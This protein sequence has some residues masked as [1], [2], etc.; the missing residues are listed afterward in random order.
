MTTTQ[1][2]PLIGRTV[3]G[4]YLVESH[5]ADGGMGS[6]YVALDTRLDRRVALKVMREDLARDQGFVERFRREARSAAKLSHPNVVAVY[7]QGG[8]GDLVWLA[9]E[10]IG[11]GRTL[12]TWLGEVGALTPREA[13]RVWRSMVQALDAAHRSG[14]LHRDVKPENVLLGPDGGTA[15]GGVVKV[16]D[17]GLSRPVSTQTF[18]MAGSNLLGTAA[19]LSPEQIETGRADTRSDVYAAG[20]VLH[21]MLTGRR[22]VAGETL[23]QVAYQ[24]VH[25][26]VPLPSATVPGLPDELDA[27]CAWCTQRDPDARPSDAATV[28][29]QLDSSAAALTA[30]QL[31]TRPALD[32]IEPGPAHTSAL[33]QPTRRVPLVLPKVP[34]DP[35]AAAGVNAGDTEQT[36]QAGK[37]AKTGTAGKAADAATPPAVR[38]QTAGPGGAAT[39]GRRSAGQGSADAPTGDAVT[40][41]PASGVVMPDGHK[42]PSRIRRLSGA[43]RPLKPWAR[44][45][46]GSLAAALLIGAGAYWYV[47]LGPA[48]T[49]IVPDVVN[50]QQSEAAMA[51]SG[52]DLGATISPAFSEDVPRGRVISTDPTPGAET[53][54]GRDVTLVVSNGPERYDVP[55]VTRMTADQAAD[56]LANTKLRRGAVEEEFNETIAAGLVTR[57]D[58]AVGRSVKPDT[59]VKLW[60]SKG[61][62]PIPVRSYIGK[63]FQDARNALAALD[64]ETRVTKEE[65]SNDIPK[66]SVIDQ[67]PR[68]G[69]IYRN[70]TINFVVSKGPDLVQIPDVQGKQEAEAVALLKQAGFEV[71]VRRE[72]GGIFGTAHST[73]PGAGQQAGRGS[74]I[75]LKVV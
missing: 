74:T 63:P 34:G 71:E 38:H 16:A 52:E 7:D 35:T 53:T 37:V 73:E 70:G 47:F 33:V 68:R 23:I 65:F 44:W 54:R 17:F 12:R 56:A 24:H 46:L 75:V 18:T 60:V 28:L 57:A 8:E 9:M 49:R 25:G 55:E 31:D 4:R 20:L 45:F 61:R 21:E 50:R 51:L 48:G 11:D 27:L 10:L 30:A 26:T 22:A 72:F 1:V 62:Q 41:L 42:L 69:T 6:V 66:G 29:A 32:G 64:L 39:A 13:L 14:V 40:G 36:E 58:P 15:E 59:A 19:Y 67:D 2:R 43:R 3:D 5:L